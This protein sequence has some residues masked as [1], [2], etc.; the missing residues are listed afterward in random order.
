MRW[1][2]LV[3]M[4]GVLGCDSHALVV[5]QEAMQ[6]PATPRRLTGTKAGGE[7]C[8]RASECAPRCCACAEGPERFLA[9]VCER[10]FCSSNPCPLASNLAPDDGERTCSAPDAGSASDAGR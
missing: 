8:L 4:A 2:F 5:E 10:G 9:S 7:A 6:C 1:A 3:V